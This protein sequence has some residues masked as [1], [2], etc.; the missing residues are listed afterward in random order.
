MFAQTRLSAALLFLVAAQAGLAADTPWQGK[1]LK[2]YIQ[3]LEQQ[4]LRIIYSSDLILDR[5][6]VKTEPQAADPKS[7]LVEVLIPYQ[8]T[9]KEGPGGSILIV[10]PPGVRVAIRVLSRNEAVADAVVNLDGQLAGRSDESGALLMPPVGKGIHEIAITANG[11]EPWIDDTFD[12]GQYATETLKIELF[13]SAPLLE[14]IIVTTGLHRLQYQQPGEHTYLDREMTSRM[15]DLGDEAVRVTDRLPG[16]ASGGVST[17][18]HVRGGEANEVLFLLDGLRLYEPYHMKDFQT[19]ATIVNSSAIA[20][21]DFYT[22]GFPVQYG[23]RMSGVMDISLRQPTGKAETELALSFF[24]ASVL[25][26]GTFGDGARGDWL[27]SARRG[28]LDGILNLVEPN[29]GSPIYQDLLTH[30]GWDFGERARLSVNFLASKDEISL[31]NENAGEHAV[32]EYNNRVGWIKVDSAW[33][34]TLSSR[35]LLSVSFIDNNRAGQ[36]DTPGVISGSVVDDRDFRALG[37]KQDWQ[38]SL[39]ETW[40]LTGGLDYKRLNADY[41]YVSNVNIVPPFDDILDN[42][43]D[44][45]RDIDVSPGGSQYAVY[46]NARWQAAEK[47]TLDAGL[48]WDRQT[49]TTTADDDEQISPR[50]SLLY[51]IGPATELRLGWGQFYQA[52]EINE[53]QVNDGLTEFFPAQG[54]SHIVANLSHTFGSGI[55][56]RVAAYRKQFRSLR[57]RFEN[58]FDPLV[59]IPDLQI[60]RVRIDADSALARGIE[61]SI[62]GGDANQ[63]LLWWASY[64]WS[65]VEDL[66]AGEYVKRSWDQTH[67]AKAGLNWNWGRWN[68][69]TA[70]IV[71]TGWPRTELLTE[72][73]INPDGSQQLSA[74]PSQR[75]NSRYRAFQS[76]DARVSRTFNVSK[77]E[78]TAFLEVTNLFNRGNP[79]CT[80]FSLQTDDNG[81]TMILSKQ[82][83]WLPIVPS[84]GFV[85]RF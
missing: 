70:G 49:Y 32:A 81:E 13:E 8:L 38:F 5:Y 14:E 57:P 47:L 59:L 62:T 77:G 67:T 76:L 41:R 25:S 72:T 20:G 68:F 16:T 58:I 75:N 84:L 2:D 52:Q 3:S 79:C 39:S 37:F 55:E 69:S 74:V 17:R 31:A 28:L 85:W 82:G 11:Y 36:A 61:L 43:A 66:V 40:L 56:L 48:R 46:V 19:V 24:N 23:D 63:G 44:V 33:S 60:D 18:N 71:R 78:L 10:R 29:P 50:L 73:L 65:E 7:A 21:I 27:V 64:A 51:R 26:I 6:Q 22:G 42:Q 9:L 53:L 80:R 1:P 45:S 15:P 54:A 30:I 12:A 34:D 83:N 4:G 35:T